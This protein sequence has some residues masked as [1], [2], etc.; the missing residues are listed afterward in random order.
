MIDDGA[1]SL[2]EFTTFFQPWHGK[3]VESSGAV[4]NNQSVPIIPSVGD[5]VHLDTFGGDAHLVDFGMPPIDTPPLMADAGMEIKNTAILYGRTKNYS[6]VAGWGFGDGG[7][8]YRCA[9]GTVY[10]M[11]ARAHPTLR[12]KLMLYCG[13]PDVSIAYPSYLLFE[14]DTPDN[15]STEYHHAPIDN[16]IADGE[17]ESAFTRGPC[18]NFSPDG[19]KAAIHWWDEFMLTVCVELVI[20]GGDEATMPTVEGALTYSHNEAGGSLPTRFV[21]N[22]TTGVA[23]TCKAYWYDVQANGATDGDAPDYSRD[24][25][26][27]KRMPDPNPIHAAA[28]DMQIGVE[29]GN[30]RD[31]NILCVCYAKD[32]ARKVLSYG[33]GIRPTTV[34]IVSE[35]LDNTIVVADPAYWNSGLGMYTYPSVNAAWD[36]GYS[37]VVYD[38]TIVTENLAVYVDGVFSAGMLTTN[39]IRRRMRIGNENSGTYFP[40]KTVTL[41]SDTT[42]Y[43][44]WAGW[45]AYQSEINAKWASL[46][47]GGES[48]NETALVAT[49]A[50]TNA[51]VV[52]YW[53]GSE[54]PFSYVNSNA[55]I[56]H[57]QMFVSPELSALVNGEA[58]SWK[59][60]PPYTGG[61]AQPER[62][63][64]V[65]PETLEY[66]P[67][68]KRYF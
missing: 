29:V 59:L 4:L 5:L 8:P 41:L 57:D 11:Q 32:G 55:S 1:D 62:I 2:T 36:Y 6:P 7:W 56:R 43:T 53:Y 60:S 25:N 54:Y 58:G 9:D 22:Q 12:T 24:G 26:L 40:D 46:P 14:M 13:K 66:D 18:A 67:D 52:S 48:W 33:Y 61:P 38:A 37:T 17:F 30:Y 39:V 10:H 68:V 19:T 42:T 16:F 45:T 44:G 49:M 35:E 15:L 31:E 34:N 27:Y 28:H 20:S 64:A 3:K 51:F 21:T 50:A 63:I 47:P 65:N 23:G